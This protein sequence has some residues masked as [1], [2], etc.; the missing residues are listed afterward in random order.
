MSIHDALTAVPTIASEDPVQKDLLHNLLIVRYPYVFGAGE[1]PEAFD[2]VD[3]ETGSIPLALVYNRVLFTLDAADTTTAHD[4]TTCLVTNDGKRYKSEGVDFDI[5]SVIDKDLT[6]PPV[7][8]TLGDAYVV[9]AG[10]SGDWASNPDDITVYTARGWVFIGAKTGQM[11]FVEDETAFYHFNLSGAWEAGIGQSALANSSVRSNHILGGRSH[12]VVVNQTTNT[13]PG[14]PAT[15]DAYIVGVSP[16]GAWSGHTGKIA[17]WSGSAWLIYAPAEGWTAYDQGDDTTYVYSGSAWVSQR[18]AI[19]FHDYHFT[20]SGSE[21]TG[22]S[23]AYTYSSGTAPTTSQQYR[24]DS[25]TITRAARRVGAVLR[26]TY[27]YESGS[28]NRS[29]PALF[30][31][32]SS[33]AIGWSFYFATSTHC[34]VTFLYVAANTASNTFKIRLMDMGDGLPTTAT[35]RLFQV[36]EFA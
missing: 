31:N 18:G 11:V 9:P 12:W 8:P 29:L 7:S 19:I 20:A 25:V 13:P 5:R 3:T 35:R 14:S 24:E 10:A 32:A 33:N 2:A 23:G 17:I 36:E 30:I 34:V 4:G 22:G 1:D 15:G 16:T 6:T 26:F 28:G 21:T 27:Q